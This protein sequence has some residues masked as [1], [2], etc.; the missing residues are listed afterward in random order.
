MDKLKELIAAGKVKP[1]IE[2]RY[3]LDDVV[4]ALVWVDDGHARGRVVITVCLILQALDA[5]GRSRDGSGS[6]GRAGDG[7]WGR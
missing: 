4:A 5:A 6:P 1:I 7:S 2:R 3:P